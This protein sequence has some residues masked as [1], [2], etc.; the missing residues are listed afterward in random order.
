MYGGEEEAWAS[1]D[2]TRAHVVATDLKTTPFDGSPQLLLDTQAG[3][4]TIGDVSRRPRSMYVQ[5]EV[6]EP[7]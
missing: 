2:V 3:T 6:S 1:C 5:I 4:L 7:R